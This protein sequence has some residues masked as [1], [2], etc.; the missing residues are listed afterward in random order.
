M[1][2]FLPHQLPDALW[3]GGLLPR[4]DEVTPLWAARWQVEGDQSRSYAHTDWELI[5]CLTGQGDL[6]LSDGA[7]G[8]RPGVATLIPPGCVHRERS[9]HSLEAIWIGL[10]GTRLVNLPGRVLRSVDETLAVDAER[11][12]R[13]GQALNGTGPEL[14]GLSAALVARIA[15]TAGGS[16]SSD[17]G[18][19]DRVIDYLYRHLADCP[20]MAQV[21]ASFG[22]SEGHFF[23]TFRRRTGQTPLAFLSAL[24]LEQAALHLRQGR[25]TVAAVARSVG[26][27]DPLYFSRAFRRR[28]GR[29]PRDDRPAPD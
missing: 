10:R 11:I 13:L 27:Q 6:A 20:P 24:R 16:Q 5:V 3:K 4:S 9:A 25:R 22:V 14:D 19:V 2:L 1:G 8:L 12:W 29:P 15:R 17:A 21:A 28:F 26:F 7:L 18:I 23:R